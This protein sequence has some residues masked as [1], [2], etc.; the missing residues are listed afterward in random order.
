LSLWTLLVKL[1]S[2][3][4]KKLLFTFEFLFDFKNLGFKLVNIHFALFKPVNGCPAL[5]NFIFEI[6][7]VFVFLIFVIAGMR[8]IK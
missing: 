3:F 1:S 7:F 6:G 2:Y 5:G 8:V 4:F